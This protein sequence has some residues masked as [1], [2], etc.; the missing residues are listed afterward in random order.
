MQYGGLP[1]DDFYWTAGVSRRVHHPMMFLLDKAIDSSKLAQVLLIE[2]GIY[3]S[4]RAT[5]KIDLTFVDQE[6]DYYFRTQEYTSVS[7]DSIRLNAF[8]FCN[9]PPWCKAI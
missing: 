7:A 1:G 2:T 5:R 3:L 8:S 9:R 4:P 6:V